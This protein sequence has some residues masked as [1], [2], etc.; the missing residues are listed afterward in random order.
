MRL[1]LRKKG[2]QSRKTGQVNHVRAFPVSE[3]GICKPPSLQGLSQSCVCLETAFH[4]WELNVLDKRQAFEMGIHGHLGSL[5][6][7]S[8]ILDGCGPAL[9]RKWKGSFRENGGACRRAF[10]GNSSP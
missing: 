5:L 4:G 1:Y 8:L 3:M 6:S 7:L 2:S 10:R 9:Q